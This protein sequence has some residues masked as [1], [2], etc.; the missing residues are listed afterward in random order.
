[1]E[2]KTENGSY[3]VYSIEEDNIH[4]ENIKSFSKGDGTILINKLKH[5]ANDL[6]LPIELYSEPQDDTIS[7]EDLNRFYEKNN[8]VLHPDDC[9]NSYYIYK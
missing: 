7:Q 4:L 9:D 3:L 2:L 8:F 5:I 1:M 6:K